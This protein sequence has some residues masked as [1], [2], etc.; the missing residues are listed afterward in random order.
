MEYFLFGCVFVFAVAIVVFAR[1]VFK[2]L[3]RLD[4]LETYLVDLIERDLNT[5][6][7]LRVL[8]EKVLRP[9]RNRQGQFTKIKTQLDKL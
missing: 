2:E 9:D 8:N 4:R 6:D 7:A 3:D 5:K 1:S